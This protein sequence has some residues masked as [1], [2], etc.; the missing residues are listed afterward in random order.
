MWEGPGTGSQA[1]L[2]FQDDD[3]PPDGGS[4]ERFM[5]NVESWRPTKFRWK[6]QRLVPSPDVNEVGCGSRLVASLVADEYTRQ[7]PVHCRGRLLDLGCGK[8]P[9]YDA[10]RSHATETMC[11][12]WEN[13]LHPNPHLDQFCDLTQDLN[14]P[15]ARFDTIILSDVLEHIPNPD[16][17]WSEMGRVLAPGGKVIGNI[18]FLYWLHEEPHDY[19][20]YTRHALQRFMTTNGFE[21]VLIE[22]IGGLPE[23]WTDLTAKLVQKVPL[24]G[25][26]AASLLQSLTRWSVRTWLKP[27]SKATRERTPLGYFFVAQRV[28]TSAGQM[29]EPAAAPAVAL[30]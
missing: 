29:T 5:K 27:L 24:V 8:V 3:T 26:P 1:T 28:T 25:P 22:S 6:G 7:L 18:P 19:Y 13:S 20:R 12:D 21:P 23:A 14:L 11:V 10:Y 15:D 9:L 4:A 30:A 17:L 16:H 2:R